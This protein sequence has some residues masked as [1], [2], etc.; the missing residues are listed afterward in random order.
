MRSVVLM[1]VTILCIG[2]RAQN[3]P[4]GPRFE[5]ASVKPVANDDR[6]PMVR[7]MMRNSRAAGAIPMAGPGRIRLEKWALLD[8]I[9][10]AYSVRTSQ[11]SGPSWLADQTFDIEATVPAGAP[12]EQLNAMLQALLEERF[13]LKLHRDRQ[14]KQG[15][16]L[17]VAKNGPKLKPAD[18]PPAPVEGL[19]DEERKA[20][21]RQDAQE[22]MAG[23]MKRMQ[24][25]RESGTPLTGLNRASWTSATSQEMASR[26]ELFTEAPVVDETGL[27]GKYSASIETWKN[28]DVPGGTVFDAVAKLGLK[29]EPRKLTIETVVVDEV[30]KTPTAN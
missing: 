25:N 4:A 5:V 24:E 21:S 3:Q 12:K 30:S 19:G 14:T 16:A 28:A 9:A 15:F 26:L 22:R 10:A 8:L 29:L 11:V 17:V 23:M 18:P 7:E 13:G 1:A 2:L 27:T 6:P 20:K